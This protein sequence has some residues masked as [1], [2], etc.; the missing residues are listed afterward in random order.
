MCRISDKREYNIRNTIDEYKK[1]KSM[2]SVAYFIIGPS[3]GY[4]IVMLQ[5]HVGGNKAVCAGWRGG[6]GGRV[7]E[8][9]MISLGISKKT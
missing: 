1:Y 2:W 8:H 4:F 9:F 6:V 7:A 3:Y 5:C